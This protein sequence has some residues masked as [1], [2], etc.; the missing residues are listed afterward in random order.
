MGVTEIDMIVA[1]VTSS[2]AE[3]LARP[4]VALMLAV[5]GLRPFAS[6]LALLI[7]AAPVLDEVHAA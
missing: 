5:P 3:A 6:P 4:S 1:L 2:V 7:V